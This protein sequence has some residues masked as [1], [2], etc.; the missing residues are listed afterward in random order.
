MDPTATQ[1]T[2]PPDYLPPDCNS[3]NLRLILAEVLDT[4]AAAKARADVIE[5]SQGL[6]LMIFML[7]STFIVI[8]FVL[9]SCLRECCKQLTHT[10]LT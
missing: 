8:E 2:T 7:L 1:I 10:I 6:S 9:W 3:T 4:R 5:T